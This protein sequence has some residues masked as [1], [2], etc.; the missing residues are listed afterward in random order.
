[1]RKVSEYA[2]PGTGTEGHQEQELS[3]QEARVTS[4]EA[5]LAAREREA[6][7]RIMDTDAQRA[8]LEGRLVTLQRERGVV[9]TELLRDM[10]RVPPPPAVTAR[11]KARLARVMAMEARV[12]AAEAREKVLHSLD[13]AL[14]QAGQALVAQRGR[15]QALAATPVGLPRAPGAPPL[16]ARPVDERRTQRRVR[17]DCEVGLETESN[18]FS[19]YGWDISTGGLFVVCFDELNVG[20]EVEVTL[21]LTGGPRIR[22]TAVVRWLRESPRGDVIPGAGLQF[23]ELGPGAEAA[24]RAFIEQR[25]TM[26]YDG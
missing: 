25:A 2:V 12:E 23:T 7:E 22:A 8:E 26:F 9:V 1:M 18:F 11:E 17:I 15:V 5:R 3:E 6:Q 16:P 4:W 19:A 13:G 20:D 24:V 10:P 21:Q 14:E